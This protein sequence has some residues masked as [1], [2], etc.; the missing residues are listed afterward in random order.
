MGGEIIAK[1]KDHNDAEKC[2]NKIFPKFLQL[3]VILK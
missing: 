3:K 2:W 1:L